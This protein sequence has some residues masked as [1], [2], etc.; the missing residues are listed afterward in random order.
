MLLLLPVEALV[1]P[2]PASFSRLK[3]ALRSA[4]DN[5]SAPASVGDENEQRR[6]GSEGREAKGGKREEG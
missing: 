5:C 2:L 1:A 3:R 6:E 4:K